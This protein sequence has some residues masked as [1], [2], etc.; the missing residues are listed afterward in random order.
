MRPGKPPQRAAPGLPLQYHRRVR[1]KWLLT[2]GI[3]AVL[4][5]GGLAV[6]FVL[7]EQA[8]A[9][10]GGAGVTAAIPSWGQALSL[11]ARIEA[12]EI[13]Q[14]P[15][16]IEGIIESLPVDIGADVFEGE[17]LATIRSSMLESQK[18]G[19]DA[20]IS[21][22]RS[23]IGSLESSLIAARL[24]ASRA[25]EAAGEARAVA[26]AAQ[27]A[28]ERQQLLYG[29]GAVARQSLES[30]QTV[31]KAAV[32]AYEAR[33]KVVLLADARVAGLARELDEQQ[34]TLDDKDLELEVVAGQVAS[35]DVRSPVNGHVIARK[36]AVGQEVTPD[37][38][39]LFRIA[40]NLTE[41]RAV[42]DAPQAALEKI[43][44]GQEAVIQIAELPDGIPAR[45]NQVQDGQIIIHFTSPS[46]F[47]KPGIT[48]Q[49]AIRLGQ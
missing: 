14:V 44:A 30:A 23:R 46:P 21:R 35:G 7:R 5:A 3:L 36:G 27:K 45:V 33:Q 9:P 42:I 26:E 29:K 32:E 28:L 15:A 22:L 47:I 2:G 37:V 13:V 31:Y 20:E 16:P 19:A 10:E 48:A 39:D 11:P 24:E 17:L 43:R 49:V 4:A 8:A 6:M 41:M 40:V 38:E 12:V 34:R 18:E 25:S 1:G